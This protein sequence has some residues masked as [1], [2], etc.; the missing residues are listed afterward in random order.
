VLKRGLQSIAATWLAGLL[1]LLP[2]ALTL[3]ALA[4]A[5]N[6]VNRLVGPGSAVGRLFAA[7]GYPSMRRARR[8]GVAEGQSA[9]THRSSAGHDV[10]AR[11]T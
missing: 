4:W 6:L 7:L 8:V 10:G 5:F 1:V 11:P 9:V 3:A 2:L